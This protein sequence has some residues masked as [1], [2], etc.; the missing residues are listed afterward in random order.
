MD[1][2]TLPNLLKKNRHPTWRIVLTKVDWK[3]DFRCVHLVTGVSPGTSI[4]GNFITTEITTVYDSDDCAIAGLAAWKAGTAM[5]GTAMPAEMGG[6]TLKPRVHTPGSSINIGLDKPTVYLHAEG[7]SSAEFIF[8]AGST[9]TT[10]VGSNIELLGDAKA[11]N[12]FWVL[13]TALTMG[14]ASIMIGAVLAGYAIT[15]GTN[16]KILGRAMRAP[17]W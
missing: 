3:S 13:G 4:T 10:C 6:V 5:T 2:T 8:Q 1:V 16:G 12:V 11:D 9:L 17:S 14:A 15:I 7:D